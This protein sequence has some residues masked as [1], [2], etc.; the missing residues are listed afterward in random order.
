MCNTPHIDHWPA[1]SCLYSWLPKQIDRSLHTVALDLVQEEEKN[2]FW[3]MVKLDCEQVSGSGNY[4]D[5]LQEITWIGAIFKPTAGKKS[6]NAIQRNLTGKK[7][8]EINV[9]G[10][11]VAVLID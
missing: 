6:A 7:V 4:W 11:S 2:N 9:D 1:F 10:I 5:T 3:R 8:E